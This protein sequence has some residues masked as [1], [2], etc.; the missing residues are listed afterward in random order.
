M[1]IGYTVT[2][3]VA[4]FIVAA[5]SKTLFAN[6]L[7]IE[8]AADAARA[9]QPLAGHNAG[10]LFAF[11]LFI[12]GLMA[13]AILPLSTSFV[14]CEG[15]GWEHGLDHPF[16]EA[17]EFYSLYTGIIAI[18][19]IFVLLPQ[20]PLVGIMFWSQVVCGFI[21]PPIFVLELLIINRKD[22]MG[23]WINP[24]WYNILAWTFTG[25]M[26]AMNLLLVFLTLAHKT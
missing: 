2:M 23:E 4:F 1:I 22:L 9:L 7:S 26:I 18:G 17:P 11:G 8:T 13:A 3:I 15:I 20:A 6:H 19:A 16:R 14:I 12:S 10:S 24:R 21:L 5:C 25:L